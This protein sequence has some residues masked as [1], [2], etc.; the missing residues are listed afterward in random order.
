MNDLIFD[1]KSFHI[2]FIETDNNLMPC[3]SMD[4]KWFW[5]VQIILV[6]YQSFWKG[7]IHFGRVQT[8]LDRNKL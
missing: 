7:P 8:I 1:T 4:P 3:P 5:T 2:D 6:K